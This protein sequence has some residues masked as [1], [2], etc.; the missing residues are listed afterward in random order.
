MSETK[1]KI[2]GL[3]RSQ[4]IEYVNEALPDYVGFV[5]AESRR[6]ITPEAAYKLKNILDP[7]IKVVGVFVN[8]N[9][10]SVSELCSQGIID[11]IQLHGNEDANYICTLR[12]NIANPVIKAVRVKDPASLNEVGQLN[13]DFLLLDSYSDKEYGGTGKTFDWEFTRS[14]NKPFF[15]AG[16]IQFENATAAIKCS[17]P[18]CL[19]VSS[20]VEINGFKDKNKILKLV[21]L[22]RSV[23]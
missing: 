22:V 21:N 2:C 11:V 5:F 16:G 20:G 6:K 12:E 7:K 4:D 17:K 14:I 1:I 15:L 19:D 23:K 13:C 8:E 3:T 10:T 18:Y 9:I